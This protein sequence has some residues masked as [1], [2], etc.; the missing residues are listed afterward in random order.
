M[1]IVDIDREWQHGD[2]DSL[3]LSMTPSTSKKLPEWKQTYGLANQPVR[4]EWCFSL[5]RY[6]NAYK[7][8]VSSTGFSFLLKAE[9]KTG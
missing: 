8:I 6:L 7:C 3:N 4:S 1:T 9:T 5:I 2:K